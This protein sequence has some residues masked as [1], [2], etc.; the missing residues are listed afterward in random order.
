MI[1]YNKI[2]LSDTNM[3]KSDDGDGVE[4]KTIIKMKPDES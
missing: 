3:F 4:I 1:R 2:R